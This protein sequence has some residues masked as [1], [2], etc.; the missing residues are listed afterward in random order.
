MYALPK[1]IEEMDKN[2]IDPKNFRSV[3]YFNEY[4][5]NFRVNWEFRRRA[6]F[7][8]GRGSRGFTRG[9]GGFRG[10]GRGRGGFRGFVRGR[11]GFRG[12]T[13]GRGYYYNRNGENRE[14]FYNQRGGRYRG[15]FRGR[16]Y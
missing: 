15:R 11:G 9:R 3:K 6:G 4:R 5:G 2:Y 7:R 12:F 16:G 13:R 1:P 8:G 14:G 10:R